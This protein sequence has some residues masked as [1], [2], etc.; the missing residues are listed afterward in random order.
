MHCVADFCI[1][2][3]GVETGVS[4]YIAEAQKVLEKSGLKYKLHGYGTGL[5]GEW[6]D[7]MATIEK[8]HARLHE[9]GVPRCATDI[10][11]GTRTDKK[12]T[13]EDKVSSVQALLMGDDK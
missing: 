4:K 3:M 7:V 6:V 8:V 11:I 1:I 2:P 9:I 5:E 13:L 12:G 10:R